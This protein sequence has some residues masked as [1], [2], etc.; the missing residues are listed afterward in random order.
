VDAFELRDTGEV[1]QVLRR[2]EP[3]LHHGDKAMPTRKRTAIVA[4]LGK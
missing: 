3:Q 4:E 1:D 2:G